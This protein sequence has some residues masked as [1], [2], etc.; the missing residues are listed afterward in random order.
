MF[1]PGIG[2]IPPWH[3][4]CTAPGK[5]EHPTTEEQAV[6]LQI[7][8]ARVEGEARLELH[9]RLAGPEIAEFQVACATQAAPLRIDLEN[10]SGASADGILALKEQRARGA[11]L[12]GA[13]PYIE[14]L[15]GDHRRPGRTT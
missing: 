5:T 1:D 2:S 12:V 9:G 10:V 14:L 8:C 13:S 11:R 3:Q 15:L 7:M 4:V 6:T